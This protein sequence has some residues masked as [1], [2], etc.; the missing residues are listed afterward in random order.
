[1]YE[2]LAQERLD[3]EERDAKGSTSR[4]RREPPVRR[5]LLKPRE[6]KVSLI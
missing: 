5:E 3:E 2:T 4:D 6:Y 1:V